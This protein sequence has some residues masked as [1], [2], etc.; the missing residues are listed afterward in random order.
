MIEL[1]I[2]IQILTI[3]VLILLAGVLG[4]CL[5][6][7]TKV[8]KKLD[9]V[10]EAIT[11]YERVRDVVIEFMNGPGKAYIELFQTVVTFLS[12]FLFGKKRSGR[13]DY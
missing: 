1:Q 9:T 8:N 12:P 4:Y 13:S 7:L 3:I 6:M 5:Y 2:T 11:Y 10:L